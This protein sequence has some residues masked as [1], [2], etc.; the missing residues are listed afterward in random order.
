M[1]I[2]IKDKKITLKYSLRAMMMYENV[3]G[4]TLNPK[5][6]TDVITFFFCVV[7]ASSKDYSLKFED[8]IDWVDENPESVK[9]FGEWLQASLSNTNQL[10]KD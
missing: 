10:K 8:F 6:L 1:D 5:G 3:S 4:S 9:E 2:T 7:L